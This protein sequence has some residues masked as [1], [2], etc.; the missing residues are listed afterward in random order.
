MERFYNTIRMLKLN[1]QQISN[2]N[3]DFLKQFENEAPCIFNKDEHYRLLTYLS[4][5]L[6]YKFIIDAGTCTG[7][8]AICLAQN[9]N[10]IIFTYDINLFE[11]KRV[12]DY[13]NIKFI[14]KSILEEDTRILLMAHMIFLDIDP[15]DGIQENMFISKLSEIN[16]RG[17][18]L[19]DDIH[20]N[21]KMNSWW[22]SI[23]IPKLDITF[24]GHGSGTGLINFSSNEI[25]IDIA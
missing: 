4:N 5:Q 10:N 16:Y 9:K 13:K 14:Q 12:L 15:H 24:L 19:C 2:Q 17:I 23:T 7:H 1:K 21:H 20:L 6:D 22:D 11:D 25:T 3:I 18:V 8:S